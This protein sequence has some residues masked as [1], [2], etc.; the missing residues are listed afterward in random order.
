MFQLERSG[1]AQH[2]KQQDTEDEVK[3]VT[4]PALKE[5][6]TMTSLGGQDWSRRC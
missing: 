5:A 2:P 4:K 6:I 3:D 1:E